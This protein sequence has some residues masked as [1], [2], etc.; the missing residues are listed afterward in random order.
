MTGDGIRE[1]IHKGRCLVRL[2]LWS[3]QI[4]RGLK[5]SSVSM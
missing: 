4:T 1:I 5:I 2:K 3:R